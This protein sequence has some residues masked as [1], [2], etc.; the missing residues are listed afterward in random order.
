MIFNRLIFLCFV[1]TAFYSCQKNQT[2]P[3]SQYDRLC[4]AST[5]GEINLNIE[6]KD[7]N[8]TCI[9]ASYTENLTGV[10]YKT[11]TLYAYN[12]GFLYFGNNDFE[13]FVMSYI[14]TEEN[15]QIEKTVSATFADGAFDYVKSN[16]DPDYEYVGKIYHTTD[17]DSDQINFDQLNS[18]K[19]EGTVSLA[20][21]EEGTN[22]ELKIS[23]GFSAD[24]E[25]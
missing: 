15:G 9:V 16:N 13:F 7:W 5:K 18:N 3:L 21:Y 20:L 8:S 24:I 14:E 22:E 17:L 2:E 23:G 11:F 12:N 4:A 19:A 10:Y 1:I 25:Q 6:N